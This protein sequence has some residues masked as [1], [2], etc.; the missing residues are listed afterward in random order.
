MSDFI[1]SEAEES[2]EEFEEKDLKPKKTQRFMEEDGEIWVVSL[3]SLYFSSSDGMI[4]RLHI[5]SDSTDEEEEE[6]T[7]DQDEQGN[8]RGL[9]DDGDE[10]EEESQRSASGGGSDSEEELKHHRKKRSEFSVFIDAHRH[11]T[12]CVKWH[13]QSCFCLLGN[14]CSVY[15]LCWCN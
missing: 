3:L 15:V 4:H 12:V 14:S 8:L 5:C 2:E 11:I 9:I 6:N 13:L 7:E 1:E 10:E